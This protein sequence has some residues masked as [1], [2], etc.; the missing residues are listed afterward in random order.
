MNG[1]R[2]FALTD[3]LL[4]LAVLAVAGGARAW[5]LSACAD[6]G[7]TDG[8]VLVQDPSPP[9]QGLPPDTVLHGHRAPTELDGLVHNLRENRWF[10]TRAPLAADDELTAHVAPA[11]PWLLHWL[12]LSPVDLG[13]SDRVMRWLQAGLGVLTAGLYFLFALRAFGSRLVAG[14][15]GFACA[16]HPVWVINTAQMADGVLATFLVAV[17]VYLGARAGQSGGPLASLGYGV[18]LALLALTRAA[19]LPFAV[20]ALVW[21]LFRSRVVRRGW[22][23]AL[24]AFLGFGNVLA[25]WTVRNYKT[26]D[27]FVPVADSAFYHLWQ[28]NNPRADGGPQSDQTILETFAAAQEGSVKATADQLAQLKQPERYNKFAREV[29]HQVQADPAGAWRHRLEAAVAFVLGSDWSREHKLWET[30]PAGDQAP[31]WFAGTYPA[32]LYGVVFG[33]LVL[34]LLGWRW[35]HGW[36]YQTMPSSLALMWVPLPYLLSHAERLQGPRLPL[37][38]VLLCYAALAIAC[39]IAPRGSGL[40]PSSAIDT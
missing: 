27:E 17:S 14:L 22:L 38:G 28:G 36:R 24:L 32:V 7:R 20:A 33:M 34:G 29:L 23:C 40:V 35:S 11:Y 9:L 12:E 25:A 15:T 5:Y 26:F 10:S 2:R 37:D 39:L 3:G 30:T 19:L 16:L 13:P 4:L 6:S 1:V 31:E 8:P 18:G 21:F